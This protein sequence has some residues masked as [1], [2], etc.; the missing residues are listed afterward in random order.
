MK[1]TELFSPNGKS[2]VKCG[3]D[4]VEYMKSNGWTEKPVTKTKEK[5]VKDNGNI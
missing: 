1:L 2:S 5:K 4:R 3:V